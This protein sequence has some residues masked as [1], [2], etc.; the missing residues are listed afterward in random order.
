MN[1]SDLLEQIINTLYQNPTVL[2]SLP[3]EEIENCILTEFELREHI[4][5]PLQFKTVTDEISQNISQFKIGAQFMSIQS[6]VDLVKKFQAM[7]LSLPELTFSDQVNERAT[8]LEAYYRHRQND[9]VI[10]LGDSHV[11]FFSGNENLTYE[12]VGHNINLCPQTNGQ[13]FT[14]FHLG[15]CLAYKS[16]T[17][18]STF[19]F[20]EKAEYLIRTFI[21]PGARIL[22]CLGE[23]D[24]RMH[25]F[26][27]AEKSGR[28]YT[29]I[30]DDILANYKKTLL[31]LKEQGFKVCV[32]SPIASQKDS[33]EPDPDFPRTGNEIQRNRATLYFCEKLEKI[34]AECNFGFYSITKELIDKNYRTRDEYI[35]EDHCHLS[36]KAVDIAKEKMEGLTHE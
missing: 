8:F 28:N 16:C 1:T 26:K 19:Q 3:W 31:S 13:P 6:A 7:L 33:T 18:G 20:R 35:C 14:V 24:I 27:Q 2:S 10:V 21:K 15:P 29:E 34:C 25:V 22:V 23:I 32:W 36:Q 4:Y 5:P 9:T 11:N 30:V 12:P 17:Y